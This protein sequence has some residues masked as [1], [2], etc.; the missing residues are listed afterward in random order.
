MTASLL[1][2][3]LLN[4]SCLS[5]GSWVELSSGDTR[6]R[7]EGYGFSFNADRQSQDFTCLACNCPAEDR[8]H[9][10]AVHHECGEHGL[11]EVTPTIHAIL[12]RKAG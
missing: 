8:Y 11:F 5:C 10:I 3:D 2:Y 4:V 7:A 12:G 6:R 9:L 1:D